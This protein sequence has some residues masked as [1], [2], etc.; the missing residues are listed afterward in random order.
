MKSPELLLDYGH[1]SMPYAET[2][3]LHINVIILGGFTCQNKIIN[4]YL[5]G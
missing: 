4:Y 1:I 5:K 3:Y 2:P